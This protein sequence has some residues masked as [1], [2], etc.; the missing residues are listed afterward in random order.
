[1][2]MAIEWRCWHKIIMEKKWFESQNKR[3]S[4]AVYTKQH[5]QLK[6]WQIV[7]QY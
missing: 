2:Q 6:S 5:W 3:K 1:M 7:P 4:Q